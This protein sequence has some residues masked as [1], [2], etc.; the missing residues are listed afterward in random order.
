MGKSVSLGIWMTLTWVVA[1]SCSGPVPA[2]PD[3]RVDGFDPQVRDEVV[4][5][6][7][8][9]SANPGSGKASGQ[10]AMVLQAHA[11]Y[12]QAAQAYRRAIRLAPDEFGW[13]YLLAMTLDKLSQPE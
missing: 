10:F 8:E 11:Q 13:R 12:P 3:V 7:R 4:Q 6:Q 5:A 9:A 2:L 1:S